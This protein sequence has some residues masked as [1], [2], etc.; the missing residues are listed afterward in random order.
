MHLDGCNLVYLNYFDIF[1][2][3]DIFHDVVYYLDLFFYIV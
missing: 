3:V 2:D 1:D